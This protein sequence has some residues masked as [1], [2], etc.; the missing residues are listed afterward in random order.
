M[1]CRMSKIA[2]LLLACV[3]LG[4]SAFAH[5]RH[6]ISIST[7]DAANCEDAIQVHGTNLSVVKGEQAE[8][9]PNRPLKV[10]AYRN[11]GVQ[12]RTADRQDFSIRL[13]KAAVARDAAVAQAMLA[14]ILLSVRDGVVSVQAP[15]SSESSEREV[16]AMLMIEAPRG[17]T[18]DMSARNGGISIRDFDGSA[19]ARTINGGISVHRSRGK[20]KVEAQN[21]GVSIRESSGDIRADVQNGGLSI[22]LDNEYTGGM[23]EAHTRNGGLVVEVP[24]TFRS[25]LEVSGSQHTSIVCRDVCD[26]GQRTWDDDRRMFRMGSGQPVVRA[27]TV[28]GGVVIQAPEDD[29]L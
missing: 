29:T 15:E 2:P 19:T 10:T 8:A 17:A 3:L 9:A 21:G 16:V 24:P 27:S 4:S 25:S 12:V 11:G 20:I 18:I 1:R 22:R 7:T 6:S 28:N 26:N 23:L 5:D 13:C 14:K